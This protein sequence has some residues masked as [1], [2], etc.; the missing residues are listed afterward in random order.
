MSRTLIRPKRDPASVAGEAFQRGSC[1]A[2]GRNLAL[3]A[4]TALLLSGCVRRYAI[5]LNNSDVIL[6]TSRPKLVRGYYV[7]KDA[8]GQEVRVNEL[9][10]RQIEA[11]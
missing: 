7:F 1:A 2:M 3:F 9:R 4:L 8:D 11:K 5:T 10:V 6:T